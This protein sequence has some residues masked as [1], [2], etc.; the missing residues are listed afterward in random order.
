MNSFFFNHRCRYLRSSFFLYYY[1]PYELNIYKLHE[2]IAI[3][4]SYLMHP[5]E[6]RKKVL[7][8]L[9]IFLLFDKGNR[10]NME[11]RNSIGSI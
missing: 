8:I 6:K 5:D 10:K 1:Y 2:E 3:H 4:A 11:N 9:L 7:T